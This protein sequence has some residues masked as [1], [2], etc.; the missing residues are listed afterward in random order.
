MAETDYQIVEQEKVVW[1]RD[2]RILKVVAQIAF[3]IVVIAA[4]WWLYS[5]FK[6][7]S[8]EQGLPQ[9]YGYLSR[10]TNFTIP[11]NP[12]RASQPALDA[13]RVG[14]QNTIA[15]VVV[16]LV[17]ATVLGVVIGVGRL[18]QNW[19]VRKSTRSTSRRCA[20]SRRW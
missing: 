9:G 16:G 18:S 11:N 6:T 5:N 17:V 13:I 3:T 8:A 7:A 10:P 19:L 2:V 12:L 15:S 1:Y 4:G 20:T 14:I